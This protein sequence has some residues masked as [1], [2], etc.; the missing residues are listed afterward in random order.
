VP[1]WSIDWIG[2]RVSGAEVQVGSGQQSGAEF[3]ANYALD[4]KYG[5]E[6]GRIFLSG[7]QALVRLPLM[8][9]QRDLA[10][11]LN[12]AGFI[13]GYRGS[14]LGGYDFA[15]WQAK[16]NLEDHHV[17]FEPGVNEDLAAT[18]VWGSQQSE[19]LEGARYDGVFGIWYG[20]G[21]GVDR[22]CD[23][24]KHANYA[25]SSPAGGVLVLAGDDPG[26]KSSSIAHQSEQAL[27]HCGIPVL[28]PSSI[29]DY[30]DFGLYGWALS[31]Y[32]GCWV[33]FK[34]LTDT[35]ESSGSVAVDPERVAIRIP[36]DFELPPQG[37][38]IS[39]S[40]YPLAVESRMFEQRHLAAQAFVRANGLD[41]V[42]LDSQ[43]RR[44]GIVT[45][46]KAY[47]DVRQALEELGIDDA[48][49]AELGLSIYKVAMPWPLEP[50][51]A[52]AFASG[53]EDLIV[54]EEKR[55]L[56]EEQLASLLYN[57][58]S[59]PRLVGKRDERGAALVPNVGELSPQTILGVLGG[60]LERRSPGFRAPRDSE[61]PADSGTSASLTRI[62][63]FCSGCPHNTSTQ[64]PDGSVAMGG[65]GC[66]G[67]AAFM[68]ERRTLAVTQMGGEGTTWIGQSRFTDTPHI[69][70]NL[71]DG[72]YFHS[73]LLAIRAAVTANV[74]IT[75]KILV[76]GAVAMTGGQP[77]EG[78]SMDGEI[79]TPEIVHQLA[80]EG[81][82]TIAVVSDDIQKYPRNAFPAGIAI[83][84]R[85]KLDRVQRQL[86]E[87]KGVS[88]IVY[89]QTCAAEARRL[90]KR[91]EFPDPDRRIVINEAVC[92][93]CGDCS[94]QSNCIAI[95]P[96]ETEFG[97]KRKINQSSCNKDFSCIKGLCPS[98][99]SVIGGRVRKHAGGV[100]EG[101]DE[102]FA[103]LP[104]PPVAD[105]SQPFNVFVAEIGGTGVVT[106]GALIG[107]AA[108]LEGKGCSILDVT[109]LAQKNGAVSSHVRVATDPDAL[110]ATRITDGTA[111]LLL[112]C[113][114]VVAAG[115][116][117]VSKLR[118]GRTTSIVN[119]HVAPT[120][121]FATNADLD[122]SSAAMEDCIRATTEDD[123]FHVIDSTR[124]ATALMGDA[125]ASNLFLVGFALQKGRLPVGI[126]A[127]ERAIELN[128]RAVEMNK[129]A[130]AWGRLAAHDPERVV[131]AARP[132]QRKLQAEHS[133][134]GLDEFVASRVAFLT[135]YQ[136]ARFARKYAT[137]VDHVARAEHRVARGESRL[138]ETVA[139]YLSKLMAYKDE[140]EVARLY[141]N[142]DFQRQLKSEFEGDY[143]LQ[144]HLSP[145][146]FTPRDRDTGRFIKLTFGPWF[147]K[148][149]EML[150][151]LK[152]LRA[153]PLDIFGYTRHR[154]LQVQMI[155]DYRATI[156]E[157]LE[158]LTAE[159]LDLAIEIAGIPEHIRGYDLVLERH[160]EDA[161]S[162]QSELLDAFRRIA[163][164]GASPA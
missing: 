120:S 122:L 71:G 97:R 98:F 1:R 110:H 149:F 61:P 125:I 84:H 53:L 74:A 63:S 94:V 141:A 144:F 137:F 133:A 73:G 119:S 29:Q 32:S 45:T 39:F 112:G 161:L 72:T 37:L 67:M 56:M 30:L 47:L 36:T 11:G 43:N 163:G 106:V 154:R 9:R 35:V 40:N 70:Q 15:L 116:D 66:H 127:L 160:H 83:H 52:R 38:N 7:V 5:L 42:M 12:T 55:P 21:P 33:G 51:G 24:L 77:I 113:D 90:R 101:H 58:S 17:H 123:D 46:G 57:L 8:Q 16:S 86:R 4:D 130:L 148:A 124:L 14:P 117:G 49:A 159:N 118:A 150:A 95:E 13:S 162:K 22:S 96:V 28:N 134:H 147:M 140:Y 31:R 108:H 41:R 104:H 2:R 93:G 89:D 136:S 92:E 99:V 129:R 115:P 128:G 82:K 91:G 158:G 132:E 50:E 65:I 76:N 103:A 107:M 64:I 87:V 152:F 54:V 81:V 19:L 151:S 121:D 3:D 60:W 111:D 114:I 23:A 142:D 88:A 135:Q 20:K 85:D 126:G 68:P 25:G 79:T 69:F 145:P 138:A 18:S 146:L 109:G 10:A 143:Q 48:R 6:S 44:L 156:T 59:R 131:A 139:R 157:L 102:F 62:P 164:N 27:V 153:T 78:E 34:C 105:T 155:S 100:V 26:A 75:Y 80:A